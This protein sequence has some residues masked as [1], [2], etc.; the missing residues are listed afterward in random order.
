MTST[1]PT[2]PAAAAA[3]AS[4]NPDILPL[5]RRLSPLPGGKRLFS[6]LLGRMVPYTGSI[7]PLVEE[8]APGHARVAIRDRRAVRNH[9]RSVHAIALANVAEAASG[10]AVIAALPPG[11]RGI[12]VGFRIEYLKKARGRLVAECRCTIPDFAGAR[13]TREGGAPS[14][15]FEPVVEV[16][17]AAGVIVVRAWPRWRLSAG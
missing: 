6:L 13:P 5:W 16:S 4:G 17:D 12:L 8:L 2:A 15:D 1:V 7:G 3:R 9:L 11:A 10:L 14:L